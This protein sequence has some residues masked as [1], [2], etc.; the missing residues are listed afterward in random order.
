M[1]LAYVL[2]LSSDQ[3]GDAG[4]AGDAN[5]YYWP[6]YTQ[7]TNSDY[8]NSDYE[9]EAQDC[10]YGLDQISQYTMAIDTKLAAQVGINNRCQYTQFYELTYDLAENGGCGDNQYGQYQDMYADQ[11]EVEYEIN[12]ETIKQNFQNCRD[13]YAAIGVDIDNLDMDGK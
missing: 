13:N 12:P 4:D 9:A 10:M 11:E 8:A 2:G 7:Y 6:Q 1:D 5:N 3:Y